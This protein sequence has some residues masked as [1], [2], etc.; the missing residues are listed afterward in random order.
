MTKLT[1]EG[2]RVV[3]LT[4]AYAGTIGGLY[5]AYLGAELIKVEAIQRPDMPTRMMNY[6]ENDPGEEYWNRAGYF[7]RLNLGKLGI[8]LDL[9]HPKGVEVFKRLVKMSDV[10]ADNYSP[11]TMKQLG[12]DYEV[13]KEINPG[14]IMVS[15]SG[16]GAY[17]PRK[18]WVAYN[19]I[20]EAAG[21]SSITG[22]A[23]GEHGASATAY[24]DWATGA[25]GAA[26][27]LIALHHRHRTGEG[28][29]IDVSGR[30]AMAVQLGEAIMDYTMNGRVWK[31]MGNRHSSM[32]PHNC[33][34]C[35]GD[36]K[37]VAIAVGTEDQWESF[38]KLIGSPAWA[39]EERF[40]DAFGRW[41]HQADLDRLIA[42]WTGQR[43]HKETAHILLEGG[44]PAAPVLNSKDIVTE[45]HLLE[46]GFFQVIDHPITGK[47][48][49]LNQ[50]AARFSKTGVAS[51][52]PAPRLGEHNELV[53]R[54]LLGMSSEEIALLE[55]E[56]VIGSVPVR[57]TGQ[58]PVPAPFDLMKKAG[59]E[60]DDDYLK[61][62]SEVYGE[63]MGPP[64]KQAV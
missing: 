34:P 16:F 48:P 10:V 50:I 55:D 7:H 5:W 41:Q 11:R 59:I 31:P 4:R 20:M 19:H 15:M 28:Q 64:A 26:A 38:C 24:G 32:A 52:R 37:W 40:S 12:L 46:R 60:I 43:D 1:L 39:M 25:A 54:D 45:P 56:Q 27:V 61:R 51:V 14:I 44:V 29:F 22:Y 17:G 3:D 57:R 49:F 42:E 36:D 6:A 18:D 63:P 58:Q 35:R 30:E 2:I 21:L 23:D 53:L 33:Y 13:L 47:R 9:T 62:L 8:T